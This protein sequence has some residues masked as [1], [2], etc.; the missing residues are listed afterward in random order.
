M[1]STSHYGSGISGREVRVADAD[2]W[3]L[4]GTKAA[5]DTACQSKP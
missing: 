1:A 3:V 4:T 5:A 2:D